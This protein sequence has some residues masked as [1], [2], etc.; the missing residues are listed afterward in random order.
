MVY[1]RDIAQEKYAYPESSV[2]VIVDVIVVT[3][4]LTSPSNARP[5][6]GPGPH[7]LSSSSH[8]FSRRKVSSSSKISFCSRACRA[9]LRAKVVL[10]GWK[11]FPA[12]P[13]RDCLSDL[14]EV[15]SLSVPL[16]EETS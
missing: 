12:L 3:L 6:S 11:A 5:P 7:T 15:S 13:L 9:Q 4:C 14:V 1:S 10:L 2:I 16:W 8:P